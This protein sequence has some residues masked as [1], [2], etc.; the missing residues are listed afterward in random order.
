MEGGDEEAVETRV[1]LL[2]TAGSGVEQM[3][4]VETTVV[5]E[6]NGIALDS[7][8]ALEDEGVTLDVQAL[9]IGHSGSVL[10][11]DGESI[12]LVAREVSVEAVLAALGCTTKDNTESGGFTF[13]LKIQSAPEFGE[14]N[15]ELNKDVVVR[16]NMNCAHT[17]FDDAGD[18]LQQERMQGLGR[19]EG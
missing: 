3:K 11:N 8:Y 5:S 12:E 4:A 14:S 15:T 10:L 1:A 19:Q 9:G 18:D 13:F 6:L 17:G 16:G 7:M 2:V